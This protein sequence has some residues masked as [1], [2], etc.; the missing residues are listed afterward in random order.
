MNNPFR[1][2]NKDSTALRKARDIVANA[3]QFPSALAIV[4]ERV[5]AASDVIATLHATH[6][7]RTDF[8]M[9]AGL[10]LAP[11]GSVPIPGFP[12]HVM[13]PE[14]LVFGL[15]RH[16]L[17]SIHQDKGHAFTTLD[18]KPYRLARLLAM[19]FVPNP[20]GHRFADYIDGDPTNLAV[21]N[22]H[23]VARTEA[24]KAK[25]VAQVRPATLKRR[26]RKAEWNAQQK[27]RAQAAKDK[28]KAYGEDLKAKLNA[29]NLVDPEIAWANKCAR[30]G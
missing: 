3:R 17:H 20:M 28:D 21:S 9:A 12:H 15:L 4:A 23:W 27:A 7:Q 8:T 6:D 1:V 29:M 11:P 22:L 13:T 26:A 14:G 5:A 30:E 16:K 2:S 25:A 19:T 24:H 10:A 18:R